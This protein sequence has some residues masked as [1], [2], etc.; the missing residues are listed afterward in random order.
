MILDV[1]DNRVRTLAFRW[2]KFHA[3]GLIGVVVQLGCLAFFKGILQ[4][5]YM[6]ATAL[7]VE[8]AVL[9]NFWW[10]E[11]WTWADRT[12]EAP[13][14]RLLLKRLARF[15]F[16]SGA[17]AIVSNLVL[18]RLLVGQL[19]LQYLV[20]NLLTIII[21]SLANFLLSEFFAFRTPRA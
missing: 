4:M 3:V 9:Q 8:A 6:A 13:G 18:M 21:A 20:A 16:T 11:R 19:H 2:A 14:T 17:V 7:A 1:A 12:R 5:H 10:H 15:N